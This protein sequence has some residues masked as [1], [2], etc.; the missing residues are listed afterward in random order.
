MIVGRIMIASRIEAVAMELPLPSSGS[1]I[2][3]TKGT[4]TTMPKKP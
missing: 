4:S 1:L 2:V 3:R